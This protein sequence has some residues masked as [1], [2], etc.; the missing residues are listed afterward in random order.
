MVFLYIKKRV[1]QNLPLTTYQQKKQA[2]LET[3]HLAEF[4]ALFLKLFQK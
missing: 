1:D 3:S 2:F 4:E